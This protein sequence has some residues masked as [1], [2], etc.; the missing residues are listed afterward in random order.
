VLK[1]PNLAHPIPPEKGFWGK[2]GELGIWSSAE[3]TVGGSIKQKK[4]KEKPKL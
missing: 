2:I 3:T 1:I 4:R